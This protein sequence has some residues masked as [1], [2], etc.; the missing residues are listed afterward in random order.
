MTLYS[1]E[2]ENLSNIYLEERAYSKR[3]NIYQ[4]LFNLFDFLTVIR[5]LILAFVLHNSDQNYF[6]IYCSKFELTMCAV[7]ATGGYDIYLALCSVAFAAFINYVY[8]LNYF[9]LN[10]RIIATIQQ[11][12]LKHKRFLKNFNYKINSLSIFFKY[13]K[14]VHLVLVILCGNHISKKGFYLK[15]NSFS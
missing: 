15:N 10:S 8:Y 4:I 9:R 6:Q 5:F 13:E 3:L 7:K 12:I 2:I 1:N 11:I 14:H